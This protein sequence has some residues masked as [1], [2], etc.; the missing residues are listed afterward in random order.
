MVLVE[1]AS[2]VHILFNY[3]LNSKITITTTGSHA[4]IPP[5][6]LSPAGFKGATLKALKVRIQ[7]TEHVWMYGC[8]LYVYI[9]TC[10]QVK[11][12]SVQELNEGKMVRRFYL[13]LSGP[14]LPRNLYTLSNLFCKTQHGQFSAHMNNVEVTGAFNGKTE[15]NVETE[16]E[17]SELHEPYLQMRSLGQ[18]HGLRQLTCDTYDFTWS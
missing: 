5:T 17:I 13:E 4:G 9:S 14:I 15:H 6:I 7:H 11:Q 12:G 18:K 8:V 3:I 2:N 1:G 10:T 16:I